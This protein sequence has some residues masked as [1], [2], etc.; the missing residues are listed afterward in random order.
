MKRICTLLILLCTMSSWASAQWYLFPG[1]KKKNEKKTAVDTIR[2]VLPDSTLL[3]PGADTLLAERPDSLFTADTL[4]FE[5]PDVF[6]LDIPSVIHIGLALPLQASEEKP[7]DNFLDMYSGAL[8]ALRDLGAAGLKVD[9]QVFDTADSKSPLS[10][11]LID[12]ND[13]VIGPVTAQEI[14]SALP[15]CS[16]GKVL[17]SPLDPKGADLAAASKSLIQ[18][19]TPWTAQIDELIRWMREEMPI[20]EDLYVI[21]DTAAAAI[22]EQTLYLNERL[23]TS[24]LRCKYVLS[25]GEIPFKKG[26]VSRVLVASERDSFHTGILRNLNIE[27]TRNNNVILYGTARARNSSTGQTELH[28][29]NAHLTLSYYIDYDDPAVQR[30][31][32]AYRSLFQNDPGSFSF[33]G[34]DAMHYFVTMCAKYGRQWYKKLTEYSETGLQ[35]DFRFTEEGGRVNQAVRRVVYKPDLTAERQ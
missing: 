7:S 21:R 35:S 16:R 8:L 2:Q 18:S 13:I 33:Q 29:T 23:A 20:G 34:Y 22:G 6:E 14:E 28:N 9:L 1:R 32:L 24:G 30:F 15:L 26:T 12:E 11:S 31:V 10:Q 25:V 3:L 27:G 4:A 5:L 19:P 17:I